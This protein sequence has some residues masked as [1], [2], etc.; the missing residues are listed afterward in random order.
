MNND[1][2][3]REVNKL[4]DFLFEHAVGMLK[5]NNRNFANQLKRESTKPPRIILAV[6]SRRRSTLGWYAPNRWIRNEKTISEIAILPDAV[7]DGVVKAANV[8]LH[9]LVHFINHLCGIV[10]CSRQGRYHNEYFKSLAEAVGLETFVV[11]HYG[12]AWTELTDVTAKIVK[13]WSKS[14]KIEAKV[15]QFQRQHTP[16]PRTLQKVACPS[17][18]RFAYL[19]RS[20]LE[21]TTLV[22]GKCNEKLQVV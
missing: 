19:L 16:A 5:A 3:L 6:A 12:Y 20:R 9:E 8:V 21:D 10:D 18:D 14:N 22:C 13:Q 17:C 15:F 4:S 7:N 1:L 2:L 11:K